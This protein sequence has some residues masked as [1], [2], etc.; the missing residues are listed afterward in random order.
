[1]PWPSPR[2]PEP[3]QW[4]LCPPGPSASGSVTAAIQGV[5]LELGSDSLHFR[6]AHRPL[7][8]SISSTSMSSTG[9]TSGSPFNRPRRRAPGIQLGQPAH[10]GYIHRLCPAL[11]VFSAVS[12]FR[13]RHYYCCR[14][15]PPLGCC[16]P[17]GHQQPVSVYAILGSRQHNMVAVD[18]SGRS[19]ACTDPMS[20]VWLPC[21][22]IQARRALYRACARTFC[23]RCQRDFGTISKAPSHRNTPN[24]AINWASPRRFIGHCAASFLSR[25]TAACAQRPRKWCS[26]W[27]A[28]PS[29]AIARH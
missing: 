26:M 7:K 16:E 2:A 8:A 9:S 25:P 18:H 4:R 19:A 20:T 1:M 17:E 5:G 23:N 15:R 12:G 13:L 22:E 11:I 28:T 27:S 3:V 21:R 29:I 24:G 14:D 10:I 6:C